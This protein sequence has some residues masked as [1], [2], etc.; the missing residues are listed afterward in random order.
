MLFAQQLT[1]QSVKELEQ[2][3]NKNN[4]LACGFLGLKYFNGMNVRQDK[5]KGIE[6]FTKACDSD[7]AI[8]CFNLANISL[9]SQR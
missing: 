8:S 7:E 4:Y 5:I 9:V 1:T 2:E 3:C 6:L